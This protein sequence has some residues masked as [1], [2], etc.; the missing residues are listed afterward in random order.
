MLL[1]SPLFSSL[2]VLLLLLTLLLSNKKVG[3]LAFVSKKVG[4]LCSNC[5]HACAHLPLM[6][7]FFVLGRGTFSLL[8]GAG[9]CSSA[10]WEWWTH[11]W[12]C[13]PVSY[14]TPC[15]Q[16]QLTHLS[17]LQWS[18]FAGSQLIETN[19]SYSRLGQATAPAGWQARWTDA[20]PF[21][22]LRTWRC[23]TTGGVMHCHVDK[24]RSCNAIPQATSYC[25]QVRHFWLASDVPDPCLPTPDAIPLFPL[26]NSCCCKQRAIIWQT[27]R[28]Q[29]YYWTSCPLMRWCKDGR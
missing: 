21:G 14:C 24:G 1:F 9:S 4:T 6:L 11:H 13:T 5:V 23:Q 7:L 15:A 16:H 20:Y 17:S 2:M 25:L 27:P 8:H 18:S 3:W 19:P 29:S 22:T 10:P 28:Y 12:L 26:V